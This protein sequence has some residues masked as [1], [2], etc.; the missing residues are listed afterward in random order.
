MSQPKIL[1]IKPNKR[2]DH[3]LTFLH[4]KDGGGC[5]AVRYKELREDGTY[6]PT[7][8]RLKTDDIKVARIF[9]NDFYAASLDTGTGAYAPTSGRK[10]LR[11]IIED[12]PDSLVGIYAQEPYAVKIRGKL[13]AETDD[14][15]EARSIRNEYVKNNP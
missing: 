11:S 3:A 1:L 6:K 8:I 15:Q 2:G 13:I 4:Q 14:I 9:R 5:W 10:S 7:R 12:D